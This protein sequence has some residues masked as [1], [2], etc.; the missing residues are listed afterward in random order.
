MLARRSQPLRESEGVGE[1]ER[2]S[3]SFQKR[4][5]LWTVYL[6]VRVGM[7]GICLIC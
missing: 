1:G 4:E 2:T 7:H 5:C 3:G 6:P